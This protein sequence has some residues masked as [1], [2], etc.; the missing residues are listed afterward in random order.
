M[1]TRAE[2]PRMPGYARTEFEKFVD[3]SVGRGLSLF[4]RRFFAEVPTTFSPVDRVPVRSDYVV[5]RQD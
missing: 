2:A 4:G 5:G 3:A 1:A